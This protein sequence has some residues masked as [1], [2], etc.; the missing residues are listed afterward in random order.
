[1]QDEEI[2]QL[3]I[4]RAIKNGMDRNDVQDVVER[5][6]L[7]FAGVERKFHSTIAGLRVD[8]LEEQR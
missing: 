3:A 2:L 4:Y 1:M 8:E 6:L 7:E 5:A